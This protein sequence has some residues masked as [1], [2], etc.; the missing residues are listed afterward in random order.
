MLLK[1]QHFPR[2]IGRSGHAPDTKKA[3]ANATLS[4]I[5]SF[6]ITNIGART[7]AAVRLKSDAAIRPLTID[8]AQ[9]VMRTTI[10]FHAVYGYQQIV[11]RII[12]KCF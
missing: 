12:Q 5:S 11:G 6:G 10:E 4:G 2:S 3:D 8:A 9:T 7:D 1:H